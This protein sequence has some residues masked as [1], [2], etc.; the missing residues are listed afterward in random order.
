MSVRWNISVTTILLLIAIIAALIL[1]PFNCRSKAPFPGWSKLHTELENLGYKPATHSTD[2]KPVELPPAVKESAA[3]TTS[4]QGYWIPES[5]Y[6]PGDSVEVELSVVVLSDETA[7]VKVVIDS[8]EVKF[9]KLEHYCTEVQ[10]KWTLYAEVSGAGTGLGIGYRIWKPLD[11]NVSPGVSVSTS[12]DWIAGGICLSK[13]L[14]SG[15]SLGGSGGG[16]V[17]IR[18]DVL[19]LEPHIAGLISIEL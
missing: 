2:P 14:F 11:I 7:W 5:E 17:I 18:D 10:R 8:V 9:T 6:V 16:R 15:V 3:A 19:I 4:G 12:L 13:N 1:S